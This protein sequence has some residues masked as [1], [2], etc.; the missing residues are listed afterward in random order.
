MSGPSI[1]C[2]YCGRAYVPIRLAED[3][4]ND[5]RCS[6]CGQVPPKRETL[7]EGIRRFRERRGMTGVELAERLGINQSQVSRWETGGVIPRAGTL[8][9]ISDALGMTPEQFQ[10]LCD[11]E[12]RE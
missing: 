10:R 3:A 4:T 11:M 2:G 1:E 12:E 7:G 6:N 9:R 5:A 8:K